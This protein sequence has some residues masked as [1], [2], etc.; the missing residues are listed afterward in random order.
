MLPRGGQSQYQTAR[1]EQTANGNGGEI[2]ED[3][4]TAPASAGEVWG[5]WYTLS[6]GRYADIE[7]IPTIDRTRLRVGIYANGSPRAGGTH[8][9]NAHHLGTEKLRKVSVFHNFHPFSP[10]IFNKKVLYQQQQEGERVKGRGGN[11]GSPSP[12]Y[13]KKEGDPMLTAIQEV[14]ECAEAILDNLATME[15]LYNE[16]TYDDSDEGR[17]HIQNGTCPRWEQCRKKRDALSKSGAETLGPKTL[18][19]ALRSDKEGNGGRL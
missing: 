6:V 10:V 8:I 14:R 1:V 5:L 18:C 2:S 4:D 11:S 17:G 15:V 13:P 19:P 16:A 7:G 3:I 9:Q 12:S